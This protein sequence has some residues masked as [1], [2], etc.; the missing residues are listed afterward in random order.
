ML[1]NRF[2]LVRFVKAGLVIG[3][4]QTLNGLHLTIPPTIEFEC[5]HTNQSSP[6]EATITIYNV[7]PAT[8]KRLFV[9]GATVELEAGYWPQDARGAAGEGLR[10]TG[11]IFKGQIREVKTTTENG[12]DVKSELKFGDGDDGARVRKTRQKHAKGVTHRTV[13]DGVAADMAKDG[14]KVGLID[15]PHY[16]E[17]RALTVDKPAWRVLEDICYQHDLL[18]SVQDGE[19]NIYSADKPLRDQTL[20]LSPLHGVIDA[21][22]FSHD[23]VEIKTLM[24][25]YFRPGY[26]FILRND[27]VVN[28]APEKY[29]IEE[30]SFSG[31]NVGD[32]FG[33]TIKAKVMI[34]GKVKRSRNRG[35]KRKA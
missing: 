33:A 8:Q 32:E 6:N 28:R 25:H 11:I 16:V 22:Q 15:I 35:K 24:L 18:W 4:R 27:L 30:I 3:G 17:P 21:P 13:V 9:E 2:L 23:G 31:S 14:I 12:V 26:T 5:N 1:Y 34:N 10:D 20:I 29:R 19:L 7:A